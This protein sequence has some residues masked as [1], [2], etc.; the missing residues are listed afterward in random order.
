M[1]HGATVKNSEFDI[2]HINSIIYI[3]IIN[4]FP[5]TSIYIH[6][7]RLIYLQYIYI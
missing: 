7:H 5:F 6:C 1:I 3:Y 2:A 4:V